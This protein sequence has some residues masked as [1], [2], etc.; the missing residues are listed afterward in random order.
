MNSQT[1]RRPESSRTTRPAKGKAKRYNRQTAH[2]EAR[3]D[4]KPLIFGWGGHLSRTEKTQLQR[5]AVW[6]TTIIVAFV[7]VA[8]VV[9]FWVNLNIIVPGLPI[10]SVNGQQVSQSDYRKLVALKAQLE[11]NKI[12]GV[13]GLVAQRDKLQKEAAAQQAIVT[14]EVQQIDALNKQLQTLPASQTAQRTNIEVQLA[15]ARAASNNAQTQYATFNG[16][17][18]EMLT[19]TVPNEQQLY[20]QPQIGNDSADWLQDDIF[21]RNWLANQS[22]SVQN[23]VN[24]SASAVNKAIADLTANLPVGMTYAKFLSNDNVSDADVHAMMAL[25]LRR[26]NMQTYLASQ[27]TSP[28]YQVSIREMTIDTQAHA[29]AILK[30][31]QGGADFAT[32]ARQKSTDTATNTQGGYVGWLIRG[33]YAREY[34]SSGS[35]LID[36]WIFNPARTVNELSPV[37][38]ENGSFHIIQI[39]GIDPSRAVDSATLQAAQ[40]NA[41]TT[42]LLSQKAMPGVKI[43]SINQTMLLDANNM[44]AGL[45]SSAPSQQVPG[46]SSNPTG[47]GSLPGGSSTLP[48]AVATP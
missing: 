11:D 19:N 9:G 32:L 21:I 12:Y 4:G 33:Q 39:L 5:R 24:P 45:P 20:D 46:S 43:T 16:Q 15:Q 13:N 42:W 26:Q 29:A 40:S 27:I 41:L 25:V 3:R 31:L 23:Q 47:A 37:M 17:Y 30:Q 22:S 48:G 38:S 18:Q 2:V 10:T 14:K 28:A 6:A 1:A 35:G 36:N 34:A 7:I 8:V 44:P